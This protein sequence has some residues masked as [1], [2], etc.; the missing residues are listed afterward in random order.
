MLILLS[1]ELNFAQK[2]YD[3]DTHTYHYYQ[4]NIHIYH[5]NILYPYHGLLKNG[6]SLFLSCLIFILF[7][8]YYWINLNYFILSQCYFNS[9]FLCELCYFYFFMRYYFHH[10]RFN[11]FLRIVINF[12]HLFESNFNCLFGFNFYFFLMQY[13]ILIDLFK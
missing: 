10:F 5:Q 12:Y 11:L 13:F 3:Q 7:Y 8:S 2:F 9:F 6:N 1:L 4:V